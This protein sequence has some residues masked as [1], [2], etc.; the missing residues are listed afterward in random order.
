MSSV[1]LECIVNTAAIHW[2]LSGSWWNC[3]HDES[4]KRLHNDVCSG[5]E[6]QGQQQSLV[7]R[8]LGLQP[9]I[10]I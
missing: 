4:L 2:L 6:F 1:M 5:P 8:I 10:P 3:P 7:G 9:W